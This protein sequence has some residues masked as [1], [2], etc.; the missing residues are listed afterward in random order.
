MPVHTFSCRRCNV[1]EAEF[2]GGAR[3][4]LRLTR[5]QHA[6]H[7]TAT[8]M[9]STCPPPSPTHSGRAQHVLHPGALQALS[10]AA[11]RQP[12]RLRRGRRGVQLQQS[13]GLEE[14]RHLTGVHSVCGD[15]GRGLH[16]VGIWQACIW[17]TTGLRARGGGGV[18]TRSRVCATCVQVRVCVCACLRVHACMSACVRACVHACVRA[19]VPVCACVRAVDLRRVLRTSMP[20]AAVFSNIRS[21]P[22]TS[23]GSSSS[24][25][26]AASH[27]CS[28]ALLLLLLP[29]LKLFTLL[30]TLLV[31][32]LLLP[33]KLLPA[34]ALSLARG[35]AK[36]GAARACKHGV[37]AP[38]PWIALA[39]MAGASGGVGAS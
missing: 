9:Y 35:R 23:Q 30:L 29:L 7:P 1:R 19:C 4:C 34:L 26:P 33:L 14:A 10:R 11:V 13:G 27:C 8:A 18:H 22:S 20:R 3:A 5:A 38:S 37:S 28:C 21:S 15:H 32:L 6:R 31:L 12:G 17:Q 36:Q 25:P 16:P 2:T 39:C 24:A